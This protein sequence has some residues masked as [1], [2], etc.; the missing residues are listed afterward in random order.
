MIHELGIIRYPL[1]LLGLQLKCSVET[2]TNGSFY[3][4]I[5]ILLASFRWDFMFV[6]FSEI[7]IVC[8]TT[9]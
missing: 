7:F 2:E 8:K 3:A 6:L 5:S 1:Y 9:G 4:Q